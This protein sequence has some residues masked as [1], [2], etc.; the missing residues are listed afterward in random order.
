MSD[1]EKLQAGVDELMNGIFANQYEETKASILTRF[2]S[3]QFNQIRN[4]CKASGIE[5]PDDAPVQDG[6]LI[7]IRADEKYAKIG[8]DA[9]LKDV[10]NQFGL[11]IYGKKFN[12]GIHGAFGVAQT[13][14]PEVKNATIILH[15]PATYA[16]E[17][18]PL[19]T[20]MNNSINHCHRKPTCTVKVRY[21]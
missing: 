7:E 8:D 20:K 16:G 9:M 19:L 5:V 10:L 13:I 18:H 17:H 14:V 2:T 4:M 15:I 21:V 1:K 12:D 11:T 6:P 3:K